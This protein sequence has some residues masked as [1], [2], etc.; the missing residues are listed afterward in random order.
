MSHSYV[1]LVV[2]NMIYMGTSHKITILNGKS[3]INGSCLT[4][5]NYKWNFFF[6]VPFIWDVIRN[7]LTKSESFCKMVRNTTHQMF[8]VS[9]SVPGIKIRSSKMPRVSL[10]AWEICPFRTLVVLDDGPRRRHTHSG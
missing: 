7:P 2:S 4:L 10:S 3:T 5:F 8:F 1:W 9:I 6:N